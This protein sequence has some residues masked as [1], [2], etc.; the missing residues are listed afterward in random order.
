[1]F[2]DN[3]KRQLE[4]LQKAA[5]VLLQLHL[6][7]QHVREERT[8]SLLL[9]RADCQKLAPCA[10]PSLH[11]YRHSIVTHHYRSITFCGMGFVSL[12]AFG[13]SGHAEFYPFKKLR[14]LSFK[15]KEVENLLC[16]TA[17]RI[18]LGEAADAVPLQKPQMWLMKTTWQCQV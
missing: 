11:Q 8:V 3:T 7:R 12:E 6:H 18:H 17:R 13:H 4:G 9:Q 5:A 14:S 1:M 2:Y 16:A 10:P 15:K